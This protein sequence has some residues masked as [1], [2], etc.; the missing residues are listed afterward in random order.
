MAKP[1]LITMYYHIS[2][3]YLKDFLPNKPKLE[4]TPVK[5]YCGQICFDEK[6]NAFKIKISTWNHINGG[7]LMDREELEEIIDTICHEFAHMIERKH[8]ENHEYITRTFK[9]IVLTKLEIEDLL[10]A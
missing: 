2:F 3:D 4:L 8:G 10:V 9:N 6:G 1:S 7:W 5:K